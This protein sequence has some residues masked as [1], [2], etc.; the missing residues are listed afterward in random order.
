V[1]EDEKARH[2]AERGV[3]AAGGG[4]FAQGA[5]RTAL[6]PGRRTGGAARPR[7]R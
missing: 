1:G 5:P 2:E 7:A 3:L 4:G 6:T